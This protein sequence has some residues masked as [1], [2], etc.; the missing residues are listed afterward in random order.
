MQPIAEYRPEISVSFTEPTGIYDEIRKPRLRRPIDLRQQAFG[1]R[2]F[3][4]GVHIA[5]ILRREFRIRRI[6]R[7]IPPAIGRHRR[8]AFLHI[9]AETHGDFHR[10]KPFARLQSGRPAALGKCGTG[11]I[12]IEPFPVFARFRIPASVGL[13]LPIEP[14]PAVRQKARGK[15]F[16]GRPASRIAEPDAFECTIIVTVGKSELRQRVF[17]PLRFS[18]PGIMR[19]NP[20]YFV[21]VAPFRS[22]KKPGNIDGRNIFQRQAALRRQRRN[23]S[24]RCPPKAHS[25]YRQTTRRFPLSG[26]YACPRHPGSRKNPAKRSASDAAPRVFLPP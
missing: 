15:I 13:D 5:V 7:E 22:G 3:P 10:F 21:I 18:M 17:P 26:Q 16:L 20:F 23:T 6:V 8:N 2:R 25:A 9:P 11:Q 19:N 24:L 12:E 4:I 14:D 1:L